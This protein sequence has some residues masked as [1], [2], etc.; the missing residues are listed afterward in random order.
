MLAASAVD[1]RTRVHA[2][3][4][5]DGLDRI[6]PAVVMHALDDTSRDV[7]A[8]AVRIAERWLG[9]GDHPVQAAMLERI[10]DADWSVRQQVAASLGALPPGSRE[11]PI[12]DLLTKH[13][14]DPTI[15][16]AAL[17]GVRGSENALL[18]RLLETEGKS[19]PAR[20]PEITIV[21]ALD[22]P[23]SLSMAMPITMNSR[24][25]VPVFTQACSSLIM[26][27]MASPLRIA[28]ESMPACTTPSPCT[29]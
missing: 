20:E 6:E 28:A 24:S 21:A 2:L 18:G 29:T 26:M 19:A 13:G 7:R 27:G 9:E 11:T 12:A 14:A 1:W 10:D 15:M 8:S 4:T 5:L 17:S 23:L 3:W 16:D 25:V 22:R